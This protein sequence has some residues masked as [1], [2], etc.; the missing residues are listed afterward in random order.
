MDIITNFG[1]ILLNNWLVG[2]IKNVELIEQ[3]KSK[4]AGSIEKK[5]KKD[6]ER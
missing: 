2:Y 6:Q 4:Q 5:D 1:T 3:L